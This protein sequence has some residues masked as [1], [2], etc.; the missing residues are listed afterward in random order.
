[1]LVA[2]VVHRAH[3]D[4]RAL[5]LLHGHTGVQRLAQGPACQVDPAGTRRHPAHTVAKVRRVVLVL[6]GADAHLAQVVHTCPH[7]IAHDAG[8][9]FRQFP[10]PVGIR[11]EGLAAQDQ[12]V[13][14]L[15][16]VALIAEDAIVVSRHVHI[17]EGVP[18][19]PVTGGEGGPQLHEVVPKQPRH[20]VEK[21]AAHRLLFLG[22]RP[23]G[24]Q[25][26]RLFGLFF[27]LLVAVDAKAD[28]GQEIEKDVH[29]AGDGP[30]IIQ[31]VEMVR[32]IGSELDPLF[33]GGLG[34]LV[35]GG[36]E[37]N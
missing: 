15:S 29:A 5:V 10:E 26:F 7:K 17:G 13:R 11:A 23:G 18:G 31:L 19:S 14:V 20:V 21:L 25:L 12:P 2:G 22:H 27:C 24:F 9:F 30:G 28:R 8:L 36:V 37:D 35:A 32:Q 1:M 3:G 4:V 33:L 6:P 16:Q 34:H